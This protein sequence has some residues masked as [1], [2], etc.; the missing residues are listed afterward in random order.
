[1]KGHVETLQATFP[2]SP[3]D[4]HC[5]SLY[6]GCDIHKN[7]P[8]QYCPPFSTQSATQLAVNGDLYSKENNN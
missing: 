3:K 7:T 2:S 1:M 8:A 6:E 5:Q 4:C